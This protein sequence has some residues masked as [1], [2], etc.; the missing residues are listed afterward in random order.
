M[1]K[2][3]IVMHPDDNVATALT[4]VNAEDAVSIE[5]KVGQV[6]K[7]VR[8]RQPISF[9]HKIALKEIEKGEQVL[10]YGEVIGQASKTIEEG[11]HV[12]VHNVE[13]KAII[14]KG[15]RART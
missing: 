1:A 11:E 3:F 14:V 9:G 7:E 15:E 12:H 8:A 5:N 10:K 4:E 6:V 2:R 13:S